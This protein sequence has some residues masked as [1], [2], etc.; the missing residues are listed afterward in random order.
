MPCVTYWPGTGGETAQRGESE[1]DISWLNRS[2]E[3]QVNPGA[4]RASV[5]KSRIQ[6]KASL[7]SMRLD[8][9]P[10]PFD[11]LQTLGLGLVQLGLMQQINLVSAPKDYRRRCATFFA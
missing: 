4:A 2:G 6:W 5:A 10:M 1:G 3:G 9:G 8:S 11:W 7:L